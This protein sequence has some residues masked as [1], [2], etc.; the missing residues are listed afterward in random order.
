MV[1][2]LF[3]LIFHHFI[4][5]ILIL[6]QTIDAFTSSAAKPLGGKTGNSWSKLK[7]DEKCVQNQKKLLKTDHHLQRLDLQFFQTIGKETLCKLN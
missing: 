5:V 1:S 4:K 2:S 7:C 3:A 6:K